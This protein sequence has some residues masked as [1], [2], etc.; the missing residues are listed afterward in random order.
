MSRIEIEFELTGLK[1]KIR[2]SREEV[3]LAARNLG[4]QFVGLLQPAARIAAGDDDDEVGRV[5]SVASAGSPLP[6]DEAPAG[7]KKRGG[8]KRRVTATAAPTNGSS[9]TS[10][11]AEPIVE[12]THDPSLFGAPKQKW[13]TAQKAI[14]L[15]YVVGEQAGKRELTPQQVAATFNKH[16]REAGQVL[17]QNV[18]RDLGKQRAKPKDAPVAEDN[19]MTPSPWYLTEA[20]RREAQSLVAEALGRT[21][22]RDA[23]NGGADTNPELFAG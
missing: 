8:K 3:P 10:A 23:A 14:W 6:S 13:N 9:T 20:G 4:Q 11:G 21:S 2:G 7:A 18:A 5:P 22:G 1:F 16:F 17:V 15:L 19:T 12:F